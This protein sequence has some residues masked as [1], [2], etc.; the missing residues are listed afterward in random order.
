MGP[1]NAHAGL[2]P[3]LEFYTLLS[4]EL[5][6]KSLGLWRHTEVLGG[7]EA[8]AAGSPGKAVP[9]S[10]AAEAAVATVKAGVAG[11]VRERT[12]HLRGVPDS[13][14]RSFKNNICMS[15]KMTWVLHLPRR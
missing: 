9:R 13:L 3:T 1:C 4:H 7:G 2:G 14:N 6:R 5:Q 15:R 10:E 8:A 12:A 11:Q